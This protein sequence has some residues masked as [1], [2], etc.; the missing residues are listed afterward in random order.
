MAFI[1]EPNIRT[2]VVKYLKEKKLTLDIM[3]LD[4]LSSVPGPLKFFHNA[5]Y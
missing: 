2:Q 3:I 5:G 1:L 4:V